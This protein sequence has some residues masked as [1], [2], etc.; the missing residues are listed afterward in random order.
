MAQVTIKKVEYTE[1]DKCAEL[2][3]DSFNTV[4]KEF[5]LTYQ[6]CPTTM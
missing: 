6:N 1:L 5:G 2:I 4:A 3:R